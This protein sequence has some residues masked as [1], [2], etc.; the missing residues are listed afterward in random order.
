M[1]Q[2]FIQIYPADDAPLRTEERERLYAEILEHVE[3]GEFKKK[4]FGPALKSL[5]F[6]GKIE[7]FN[8][9]IRD[10][11]E[12]IRRINPLGTYVHAYL[13][14]A[15]PVVSEEAFVAILRH[16][17]QQSVEEMGSEL[18]RS[19]DGSQ[20]RRPGPE[21]HSRIR[22]L[23]RA[24]PHV[25]SDASHQYLCGR[26]FSK[27]LSL[28]CYR[29]STENA[30]VTDCWNGV[31]QFV[32]SGTEME[33][34]RTLAAT[35]FSGQVEEPRG[36]RDRQV[37]EFCELYFQRR[38]GPHLLALLDVV[39]FAIPEGQRMRLENRAIVFAHLP[40]L[41]ASI[42]EPPVAPAVLLTTPG[43]GFLGTRFFCL[44][45]SHTAAHSRDLESILTANSQSSAMAESS[46]TTKMFH[47]LAPF[48]PADAL[49]RVDETTLLVGW[50][51]EFAPYVGR[52]EGAACAAA[53]CRVLAPAL[54]LESG[55]VLH[56]HGLGPS[57][58]WR[59]SRMSHGQNCDNSDSQCAEVFET[60]ELLALLWAK[61]NEELVGKDGGSPS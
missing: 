27:F 14:L 25:I 56:I 11:G 60:S 55:E 21:L 2:E 45:R 53:G 26:M 12:L 7:S 5:C 40:T 44:V 49:Q 41:Q 32:G 39:Y 24:L 22:C 34:I 47:A 57:E 48:A 54:W 29:G 37:I 8:E 17:K 30:L 46:E 4:T 61:A 6:E 3:L 35:L 13:C 19:F 33:S 38:L 10:P 28:A 31:E 9:R 50:E 15:S 1:T 23:V 16:Y 20:L 42:D 52:E 59:Y 36:Y 18:V 43:S 51:A 58:A